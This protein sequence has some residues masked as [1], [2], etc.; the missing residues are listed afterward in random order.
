MEGVDTVSADW[1]SM[2]AADA[3]RERAADIIK[4]AYAEG[5]LDQ[6]EHGR[7][8]DAILAARTYGELHRLVQD[9]PMGPT[10]PQMHLPTP[11]EPVGINPWARYAPVPRRRTE[12]LAIA[13]VI[14]A[15]L[16]PFSCGAT[17]VPALITGHMAL[18]RIR[19][20]GDEGRGIAIAGVVVG[21]VVVGLG[22]LILL[23][24]TLGILFG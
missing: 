5:R 9:L 6:T 2:R 20:S 23:F 10:P 13:S 3:D 21:H 24:V 1:E 7:R 4:A 15:G 12:P 22:V 8:L 18:A 11:A 17:S 16:V 14:L 19:R